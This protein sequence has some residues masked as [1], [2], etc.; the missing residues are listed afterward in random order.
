[1][2]EIEMMLYDRW[3]SYTYMKQNYKKP[4]VI[5]LSGT[6]RVLR[7]RD[8]GGN[9]K[10]IQYKSNWNCHCESPPPHMMSIS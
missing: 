9:V 7:G 1:M 5:A 3:T 8:D 6:G 10:N 2:K 4:L